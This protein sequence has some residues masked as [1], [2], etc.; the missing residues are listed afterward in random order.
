MNIDL[1]MPF[2]P[3]KIMRHIFLI[4]TLIVKILVQSNFLQHKPKLENPE[5][6]LKTCI[7]IYI[8][9]HLIKMIHFD[10]NLEKRDLLILYLRLKNFVEIFFVISFFTRNGVKFIF[11]IVESFFCMVN[12]AFSFKKFL[13][14]LSIFVSFFTGFIYS[15]N[16]LF[17]LMFNIR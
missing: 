10:I 9:I 5:F 14:F 3:L 2:F 6:F 15:L 16:Y 1:E 11:L 7:D 17:I 12:K 4:S 8:E 13:F